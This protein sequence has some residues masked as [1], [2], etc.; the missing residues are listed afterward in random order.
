MCAEGK[1]R[2]APCWEDGMKR[3]GLLGGFRLML[4][5]HGFEEMS[6]RFVFSI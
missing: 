4:L 1:L 2:R 5:E 6:S 3:Q